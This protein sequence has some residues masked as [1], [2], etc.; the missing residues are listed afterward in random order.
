MFQYF[1][2]KEFVLQ[3]FCFQLCAFIFKSS[4]TQT[5]EGKNQYFPLYS[6]CV[7]LK[8][9]SYEVFANLSN[10]GFTWSEA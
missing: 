4:I 5:P 6:I 10:E 3:A 1:Y 2:V 9:P 8:Q 7:T